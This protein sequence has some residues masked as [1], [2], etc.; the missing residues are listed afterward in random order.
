MADSN[1][2]QQAHG[3]AGVFR[4][5]LL[6]LLLSACSPRQLIVAAWPTNWPGRRRAAR[7]IWS[8]CGAAPLSSETVQ[9]RFS[10]GSGHQALARSL[11]AGFT[12]YAYA[13]VAFGRADRSPAMPKA[14]EG[15]ASVPPNSTPRAHRHAADCA[16]NG[17]TGF[18]RP[19]GSLDQSGRLA[20]VTRRAGRA[21]LLGRRLLG[22]L[23]FAE[24]DDP[25]VVADLPLAVRLAQRAW[26]TDPAGAGH[27]L[28]GLLGGFRG[29][30][31]GRQARRRRWPIS[32]RPLRNP[33]AAAPGAARQAEGHASRPAGDKELFASLPPGAGYQDGRR[34]RSSPL[35]RKIDDLF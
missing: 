30:T 25:D 16:G 20:T 11:A 2:I 33:P 13:F 18:C 31:A 5:V 35:G 29:G 27:G 15:C 19:A 23:D 7:T 6:A 17:G 26:A 10:A 9:S 24:Q 22:R 4:I 12:Q 21:G 32:T 34:P 3:Q 8:C 1:C 28:T 14:A